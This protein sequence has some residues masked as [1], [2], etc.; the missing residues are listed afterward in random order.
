MTRSALSATLR[1]TGII[2]G[3]LHGHDMDLHGNVIRPIRCWPCWRVL[4]LWPF[5]GG[6]QKDLEIGT[7]EKC[8]A[9]R[10]LQ[11][12][13]PIREARCPCDAIA[14]ERPSAQS[15][16]VRSQEDQTPVSSDVEPS[17]CLVLCMPAWPTARRRRVIPQE[18]R[19][20]ASSSEK[21]RCW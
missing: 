5:G 7:N 1:K 4:A 8:L 10:L 21:N 2:L 14:V 11:I 18:P 12:S 9:S 13:S 15:R 3:T 19:S 20:V 6:P 16:R 17:G